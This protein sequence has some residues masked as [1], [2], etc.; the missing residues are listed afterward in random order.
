M[1]KHLDSIFALE[2]L[3]LNEMKGLFKQI[4]E[5]LSRVGYKLEDIDYKLS[6]VP[7]FGMIT[8]MV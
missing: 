5:Y 2:S 7:D 3:K 1:P 4:Y 6:S 8:N